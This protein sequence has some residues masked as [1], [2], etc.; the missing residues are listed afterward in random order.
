MTRA[1]VA[2]RLS[3]LYGVRSLRSYVY[4]KVRTDPAYDA[5]RERLRGRE[6]QPL[7]DIGC[8]VGALAFFLREHGF[9]GPIVGID[10][11][12]RK[13][14]AARDAG[15]QYQNVQFLDADA[16]SPLPAGHNVLLLDM[17]QYVEPGAQQQI[18]ENVARTIP[19]GGIVVT[20]QGVRDDSWRHKVT[21]A[22]DA[23]ARKAR[24]MQAERV[25]FPT[26]DDV[27]RPFRDG[28]SAEITPLWGR[29]PFNNYLFV[30]TRREAARRPE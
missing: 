2:K 23:F 12:T 5:V 13:I 21:I 6:H 9:S 30:F 3:L 8:G 27:S 29:T 28:F 26:I 17:L 25:N 22:A 4:W 10:F 20:R 7:L 11:D 15:R 19:P 14:A 1:Q 18:L 16:R 24:W